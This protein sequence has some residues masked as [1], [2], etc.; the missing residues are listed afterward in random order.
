MA[1]KKGK[2]KAARV[3]SLPVREGSRVKGGVTFLQSSAST[4][5]KAIGEALSSAA[6]K[7]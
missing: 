7:T 4:A 1:K 3:R 5:I 2:G 6:R